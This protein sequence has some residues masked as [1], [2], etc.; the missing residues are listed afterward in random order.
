MVAPVA[1]R[2]V[3]Y[4]PQDRRQ[5]VIVLPFENSSGDPA[6]DGVAAGIT[7]DVMDLIAE[8]HAVPVI[9]AATAAAYRGKT[10]DL[11][12]IGRDHNVHFALTGNARRQDGRLIVTATL[13]EADDVR[14]VWSRRFDVPDRPNGWKSIIQAI[15]ANFQRTTMD[16]EA[17]RAMREHPDSLDKRDLLLAAGATSLSPLTRENNLTRIALIERAL[18]IDP[19]D[20]RALRWDAQLHANRVMDGFSADR[21]ADLAYAMKVID[22]AL[23]LAPNDV[24]SETVKASVLRAQGNWDA[25]A[26]LFRKVIERL[27]V[28]GRR[29]REFGSLLMVQGHFKE[30]L[31]NFMTA[32]ELVTGTEPIALFDA[33]I[34]SALLANDRYPE[35]ITQ[36]RLAISEYPPGTGRNAEFPWLVL[37]AAESAN[38]QDAEA[39]A[40]LQESLATPRTWRTMAEI[41]KVPYVAANTK[42]LEGLRRAGMPAE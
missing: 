25:A 16:V 24:L 7:R 30:A 11:R 8:D 3:A 40:N 31:E 14:T 42:L 13:Y 36:A 32:K 38:G 21:E 29:Y 27:P 41:Q 18:A 12:V 37:I 2:P 10:L 34:A 33:Q 17:A 6:Q 5:S 19:N 35:A 4:S 1:P 15:Y 22:R 9:P 20:V 28:Q 23:L 39:R 26:V